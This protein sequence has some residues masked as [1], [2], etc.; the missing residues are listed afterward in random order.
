V[1]ATPSRPPP[2][3]GQFVVAEM[4]QFL[5]AVDKAIAMLS[6]EVRKA[7]LTRWRIDESDTSRPTLVPGARGSCFRPARWG[8]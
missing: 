8:R 3:V 2:G 1:S 7:R 6:K 5:L 4:G